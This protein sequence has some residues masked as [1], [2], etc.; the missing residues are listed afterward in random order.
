MTSISV[1]LSML[2][3]D[4]SAREWSTHTDFEALVHTK[5]TLVFLMG[6]TA[7]EDICSGLMKAGMDPDM[8]A[9]VLSKGT[10]AGQQRVV[11]TVATLKTA[12]IRRKS[13][14]RPLL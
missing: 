9:A 5:G 7:M 4:I 12:L 13:R 11:A 14:H 3:P 1:R 6:I 10:T 8:P 2:S